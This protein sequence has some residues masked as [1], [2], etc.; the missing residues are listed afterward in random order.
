[1]TSILPFDLRTASSS[2]SRSECT[3]SNPAR[4]RSFASHC[5]VANIS[6]FFAA[7]A[8]AIAS[9]RLAPRFVTARRSFSSCADFSATALPISSLEAPRMEICCRSSSM[10]L[11]A[12]PRSSVASRCA[13]AARSLAAFSSRRSLSVASC[14]ARAASASLR[15]RAMVSSR[16]RRTPISSRSFLL[17]SSARTCSSL[18][19]R[20]N[21]TIWRANDA[22]LRSAASSSSRWRSSMASSS[23][24][25]LVFSAS[26]SSIA[27]LS[28][29]RSR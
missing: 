26:F 1:M 8:L 10:R 24:R 13:A 11:R 20:S 19:L 27:T 9:R 6:A 25:S 5:A 3:A 18:A 23:S 17:L 14:T 2:A 12:W 15:R 22:R 29:W 21:S 16:C 7:L 28:A 4:W